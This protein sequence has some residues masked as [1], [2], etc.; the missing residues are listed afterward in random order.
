MDNWETFILVIVLLGTYI[1][2][3]FDLPY[4]FMIGMLII[5]VIIPFLNE[6]KRRKKK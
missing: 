6:S 1:S 5:C 3:K 4:G 2:G